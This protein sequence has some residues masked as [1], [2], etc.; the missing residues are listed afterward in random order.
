MKIGSRDLAIDVE[1]LERE[2][3]DYHQ[4]LDQKIEEAYGIASEAKGPLP[5]PVSAHREPT[6]PADTDQRHPPL[7]AIETEP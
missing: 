6:K 1:R 3:D 7:R 2:R 5:D 4:K